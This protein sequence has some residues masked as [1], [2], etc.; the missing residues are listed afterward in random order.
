MALGPLGLMD[1]LCAGN[2]HRP[3]IPNHDLDRAELSR[4]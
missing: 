1:G 3:M 2:S 4:E